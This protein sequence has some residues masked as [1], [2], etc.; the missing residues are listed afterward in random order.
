M[1][2]HK[3]MESGT[4]VDAADEML[5]EYDF[6]SGIRGKYAPRVGEGTNV[7]ILDP[8][9]SVAFPDSE[10]VNR[11]LRMLIEIAQRESEAKVLAE[12][13]AAYSTE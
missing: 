11:A 10:S 7:V 8:D 1:P 4:G 13:R 6:S 3:A 5:E 9:V 12:K 2:K